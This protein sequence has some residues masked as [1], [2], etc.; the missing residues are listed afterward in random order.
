M[1]PRS[2]NRSLARSSPIEEKNPSSP[3]VWPTTS[4]RSRSGWASSAQ[5]SAG[6][7]TRFTGTRAWGVSAGAGDEDPDDGVL[8]RGGDP[9]RHPPGQDGELGP[10][11]L[12]VQPHPARQGGD[13]VQAPGLGPPLHP[14]EAVLQRPL[15]PG[16]Q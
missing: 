2:R 7:G 12:S 16:G 4:S 5:A 8:D 14:V 15:S 11:S 3:M 9:L 6:R 10:P 13:P 1:A